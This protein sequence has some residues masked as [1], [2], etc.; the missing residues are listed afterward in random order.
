MAMDSESST[1][2]FLSILFNLLWPFEVLR[3][4]GSGVTDIPGTN[5]LWGR[6]LLMGHREPTDLSVIR[7]RAV[8]YTLDTPGIQ[9]KENRDHAQ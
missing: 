9:G 3:L 1:L 8:P 5:R 7:S 4:D 6:N 2:L